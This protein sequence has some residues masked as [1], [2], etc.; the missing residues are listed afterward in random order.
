MREIMMRVKALF[1]LIFCSICL[2]VPALAGPPS[3][4][5]ATQ[6]KVVVEDDWPGLD[7]ILSEGSTTCVGGD[8][9]FD[10]WGTPYCPTGDIRIRHSVLYGCLASED[11]PRANGVG[12][13]VV[14]GNLDSSYS[15]PVWG[16]LIVVPSDGC[17]PLDLIYPTEYW[18]GVWWGRRSLQIDPECKV[19]PD[20]MKWIGDVKV[21]SR[22]H[23]GEIRGLRMTGT[24]I[25]TTFTPVP[26]PWELIPIPGFPTGPE[27]ILTATIRK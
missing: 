14:N 8:M 25:I 26:V 19:P 20:C 27:G 1:L 4:A 13:F 3:H 6:T 17:D 5:G 15:G 23:G 9:Q 12:A 16:K 18:K 22:G 7:A 10:Q 24:E 11:D 21:F 2:W